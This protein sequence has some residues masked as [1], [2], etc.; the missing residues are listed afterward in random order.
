MVGWGEKRVSS[1]LGTRGETFGA[2]VA[3]SEWKR[4]QGNVDKHEPVGREAEAYR[5]GEQNGVALQLCHA[6]KGLDPQA[7]GD[8][9]KYR[10]GA[11]IFYTF[12]KSR[13]GALRRESLP[14]VCRLPL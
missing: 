1:G 7:I 3:H 13:K 8:Y 14:Y 4:L 12:G 5:R 11:L 6:R 9:H 10:L 2:V